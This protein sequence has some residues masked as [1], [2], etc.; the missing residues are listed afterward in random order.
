[1]SSC[2]GWG[3]HGIAA[4]GYGYIQLLLFHASVLILLRCCFTL[5]HCTRL[6]WLLAMANH[7]GYCYWATGVLGIGYSGYWLSLLLVLVD[8]LLLVRSCIGAC[9][10][11][12]YV[13]TANHRANG[14]GECIG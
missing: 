13:L 4:A 3:A 2:W 14:A 7:S 11:R 5:I 6:Y 9:H 10:L 1:M 8:M 12:S